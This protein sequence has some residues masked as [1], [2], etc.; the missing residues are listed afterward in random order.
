M[1]VK[2]I[3]EREKKPKRKISWKRN[4]RGVRD[5]NTSYYGTNQYNSKGGQ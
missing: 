1:A 3:F 5:Q 4:Y 2:F